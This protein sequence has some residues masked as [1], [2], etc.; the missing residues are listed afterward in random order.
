MLDGNQQQANA[1]KKT[2]TT[3]P[4]KSPTDS[5][6]TAQQVQYPPS[7]SEANQPPTHK[8]VPPAQLPTPAPKP[9]E[10][11]PA[12]A[13]AQSQPQQP[14]AIAMKPNPPSTAHPFD[15]LDDSNFWNCEQFFPKKQI[16]ATS[17]QHVSADSTKT[18][19]KEKNNS[20]YNLPK[21]VQPTKIVRT[22]T[23]N[24]PMFSTQSVTS[25]PNENFPKKRV[26]NPYVSTV[27]RASPTKPAVAYTPSRKPNVAATKA[28]AAPK[29]NYVTPTK[30]YSPRNTSMHKD[31]PK[32]RFAMSPI[33]NS[34]TPILQNPLKFVPDDF[35]IP[36]L[37]IPPRSLEKFPPTQYKVCAAYVKKV[38]SVT[39][40]Y[41]GTFSKILKEPTEKRVKF[42][43]E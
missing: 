12:A 27:K 3:H 22:P 36:P 8:A 7:P 29:H 34:P 32:T 18:Y 1:T 15:Q 25:M 31:I 16:Y 20:D 13:P 2:K 10:T 35:D 6:P 4:E 41:F 37:P 23:T 39:L 19:G 24:S 28:H 5:K 9:Y 26:T 21:T 38:N 17:V 42:I 43:I 33:K 30:T 14:A 40:E 11:K